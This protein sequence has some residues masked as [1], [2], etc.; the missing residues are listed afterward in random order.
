MLTISLISI[1][2]DVGA[3]SMIANGDIRLKAGGE[4]R[5][6]TPNGLKFTDGEEL[7]ADVVVFATG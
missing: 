3:S 4:I 7:K 5:E 1:S 2:L 6:F